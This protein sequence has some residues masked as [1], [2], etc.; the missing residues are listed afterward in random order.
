[1]QIGDVTKDV[2]ESLGLGKAQGVEV[3]LVEPGGPADKAGIKTGRHHPEVQRRRDRAQRRPAAHG[4]RD[5]DRAAAPTVTVWRKGASAI[6]A[7]TI[8]E[9]EADKAAARADAEKAAKPDADAER[10]R[11]ARVSD[12]TDAQ[13]KELKVDCGVLVDAAEGAAARAGLRPGDTD[14]AGQQYRGQ[15]R[16]A[17][18]RLVAKLD[19]KKSVRAAGTARRSGRS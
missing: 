10:A 13:T 16:E 11:S 19:S 8:A 15:G 5:A 3:S 17:V 7:L 18:Q 1:M 12:L 6:S 14:S 9:L 4:R 2:A